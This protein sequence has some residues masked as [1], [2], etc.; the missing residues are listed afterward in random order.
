MAEHKWATGILTL[1]L[2]GYNFGA[3]LQSSNYL[4]SSGLEPQTVPQVRHLGV[5]N[6]S[7]PKV[8][9]EYFGRLWI[10]NTLE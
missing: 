2:G 10:L 9:L 7:K 6:S 1:L 3:P 5:S 4:V 8:W